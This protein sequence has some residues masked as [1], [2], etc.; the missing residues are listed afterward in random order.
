MDSRY[1][2]PGYRRKVR[3]EKR[4]KNPTD[5]N[6]SRRIGVVVVVCYFN[7]LLL[8]AS[9]SVQAIEDDGYYILSDELLCACNGMKEKKK[10][11]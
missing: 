5:A 9:E 10:T 11:E 1:K 2:I 6:E 4:L 8:V 7:V 3:N